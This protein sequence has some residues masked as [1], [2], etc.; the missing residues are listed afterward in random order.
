MSR[1]SAP[2]L[3]RKTTSIGWNKNRIRNIR[4]ILPARPQLS[5]SHIAHG[6]DAVCLRSRVRLFATPQTVA[7][8]APLSMGFSRQDYWSG[9]P[10]PPLEDLPNPG[11]K[12]TALVDSLPVVRHLGSLIHS[13]LAHLC[14]SPKKRTTIHSSFTLRRLRH[15]DAKK[16]AQGHT[17]SKRQN[18]M[19]LS[20]LA[21]LP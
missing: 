4:M 15:R 11:I 3:V 2:T 9:L 16:P 12:S 13:I 19:P 1:E 6:L 21:F 17:A 18:S 8:Q 10:L 5:T 20:V 14:N 7:R